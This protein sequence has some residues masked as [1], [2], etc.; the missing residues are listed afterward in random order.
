MKLFRIFAKKKTTQSKISRRVYGTPG[1]DEQTSGLPDLEF[2]DELSPPDGLE[3]FRMM[4]RNEPIVGGLILS[5]KNVIKRV[6]VDFDGDNTD[7]VLSQLEALPGGIV[8]LV[9]DIASAFTYG[10]YLGEKVWAVDGGKVILKDVIP[11]YQPTINAIDNSNGLVIQQTSVG[12]YEIPYKK[13]VHHIFLKE[14]RSPYGVSLLRHLYKPYYYK[15]SCEAAEATGA[16]RDLTGLPLLQAP[17]GFDFTAAEESSPHYDPAVAAT[18][19]WAVDVVSNVRKDNQQGLVIP[20]G[21]QFSLVRSDGRSSINTSEIIQRYNSEMA[22]GLLESFL[23]AGSSSLTSKGNLEALIR[24]FLSACD[25]Y[26][27]SIEETINNQIISKICEYNNLAPPT[28]RFSSTNVADLA[29]LA[30]FVARL[31]KTGVITPTVPME[32]ALLA[33]ASLPYENDENQVK[34]ITPFIQMEAKGAD[35]EA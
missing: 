30:S 1:Y 27:K 3:K 15:V 8:G 21:W 2:M 26:I 28:I 10:F 35:T 19:D 9:E 18:L 20:A 24:V 6:S 23:A 7:F 22:A 13:C 12:R 25:A 11:L 16:D 29:D 4:E 31:V 33:I 14:G 32:K 5:I 34:D 17:E